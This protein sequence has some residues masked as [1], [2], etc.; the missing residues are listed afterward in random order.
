MTI[1]NAI[2]IIY[3]CCFLCSLGGLW[4]IESDARSILYKR[5]YKISR[6]FS[7]FAFSSI[8]LSV[9]P[10]LNFI[11]AYTILFYYDTILKSAIAK[12]EPTLTKREEE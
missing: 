5:G 7:P 10:I 12:V 2:L 1:A 3:L 11:F 8:F 9:C 4:L 6:Y